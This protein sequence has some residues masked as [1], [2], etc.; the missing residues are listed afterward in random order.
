MRLAQFLP[1][2]IAIVLGIIFSLLV[3]ML[4]VN[5]VEARSRADVSRILTL[6]GHEWAKVRVDGLQ[7]ELSGTA[8]DEATR[9]RALSAAGT[10]VDTARLI[11]MMDVLD[12]DAIDPPRFSIEILR[13]DDGISL[14][15]LV[16]AS[17][18]RETVVNAIRDIADG[19]K[20]VDLLNSADYPAPEGWG[21]ALSYGMTALAD[22]PRSKISIAADRVQLKAIS[23]SVEQ[24]R[25]LET[26][27]A[28]KAPE[29]L[30]VA[31]D[32]TAPRP[33]IT[34]YTLRFIIDADGPRF[35]ACST[36]TPEGRDKILSA[37]HA[38]GLQGKASC[39]I[40][41]GVPSPT[42]DDAVV[43]AI[44]K[45][46]EIGGGSVTFSD[47]DVTLVALDSTP[48]N[49]FDR[50]V[51]ELKAD[52]PDAFSLHAVLPEPVVIDG[53]DSGAANGP[54]EFIATRS[55]EGDVRLR[56]RI[57]DERTR[58]AAESFAQAQF[59][60]SV[61]RGAM[62]IDPDL[63]RGWATR[64]LA[65]LQALAQL[66]SG[67]VVTQPDVVD[68]RGITGDANARAEIARILSEKLGDSQDFRISV[69]YEEKLDPQLNIPTPEECV[70]QINQVLLVQQITFAPSSANIDEVARASIDNIAEIMK[71]C[72]DVKMEVGG[73]TDS[74]GRESMNL[75]LSQSR[76]EAVVNA[77]LARRILT[78]NLTAKG[79]G[80]ANPVADNGTEEGRNANRRIAFRLITDE[81]IAARA[82]AKQALAD[83]PAAPTD[84]TTGTDT[85]ADPH[86]TESHVEQN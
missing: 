29:G 3:A 1:A 77:L 85:G 11:D 12:A 33:V 59:G 32:I 72:L 35:D 40:G 68:I 26:D 76:A 38:V 13:N 71:N 56:G 48:Q 41:L 67:S 19:A 17:M 83:A 36:F 5:T 63:P 46:A 61:V 69:T 54:P 22:L 18:D 47:G 70:A 27:L 14:I 4:A 50:L 75:A 21:N 49:T 16:P 66:N 78:S 2:F 39:T 62:R 28:R 25:R 23:D 34:P 51:G 73:Y 80:E 7:V 60:S 44:A 81:E 30:T 37:A 9:F 24:K 31:I 79:Y 58:V 10:V 15:G 65:S 82:A 42:W 45:L 8:P 53:T 74:Q 55:P 52:L 86:Q 64:V 57:P 43:T 20:V 6:S 84:A